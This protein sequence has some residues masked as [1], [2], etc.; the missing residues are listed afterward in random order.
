MPF[1][2]NSTGS[3]R[4]PSC[5][6][7]LPSP[8][9][10]SQVSPAA[11][12]CSPAFAL[13]GVRRG[14]PTRGTRGDE[15]SCCR[16]AERGQTLRGR[17]RAGWFCAGRWQCGLMVALPQ[18]AF[19]LGDMAGLGGPAGHVSEGIGT[20]CLLAGGWLRS[21]CPAGQRRLLLAVCCRTGS[22]GTSSLLHTASS[23]RG[24]TRQPL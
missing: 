20:V 13:S 22:G 8:S 16:G 3:S 4:P 5:R 6:E 2:N 1:L 23:S 11:G 15:E 24:G 19:G 12:S 7:A 17:L 10:R 21:Q 9:H 18:T 14:H